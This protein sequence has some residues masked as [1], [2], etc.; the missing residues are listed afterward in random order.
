MMGL[1]FM[2]E[3]VGDPDAGVRRATL[4]GEADDADPPQFVL[5]QV[6]A[7]LL[8]HVAG[9]AKSP[10]R[11]R[12][13][14]TATEAEGADEQ[15]RTTDGPDNARAVFM[16]HVSILPV[17]HWLRTTSP[18]THR[19]S[20]GSAV[21]LSKTRTGAGAFPGSVNLALFHQGLTEMRRGRADTEG[22]GAQGPVTKIVDRRQHAVRIWRINA[23]PGLAVPS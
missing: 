22:S 3:E 6:R 19:T 10:R 8:R 16:M 12:R 4:I 5:G 13:R 11:R 14:A 15:K 17:H 1:Q 9:R 18:P 21:G 2:E 20:W 23:M 7:H